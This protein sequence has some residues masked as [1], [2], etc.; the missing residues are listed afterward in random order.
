[1]VEFETVL[2]TP[3]FDFHSVPT[4]EK[5]PSLNGT[6]NTYYCGSHFGHGLHED[7]VRSAVDVAT[8]LG[9]ELPWKQ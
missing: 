9:V 4:I 5:L 1:L 2:R 7:A 3:I 8:M 6:L